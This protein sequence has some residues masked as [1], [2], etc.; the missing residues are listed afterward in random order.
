MSRHLSRIIWPEPT[1]HAELLDVFCTLI[2]VHLSWREPSIGKT[3]KG[4]QVN[5]WRPSEPTA[6]ECRI[7]RARRAS[8]QGPR[9]GRRSRTPSLGVHPQIPW[10][11]PTETG[12]WC[13]QARLSPQPCWTVL[14]MLAL[15]GTTP[16]RQSQPSECVYRTRRVSCRFGLGL[17]GGERPK[18]QRRCLQ[19][20]TTNRRLL[21]PA[22]GES[23][24]LRRN[25]L[26]SRDRSW[27]APLA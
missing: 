20:R 3:R 15:L 5:E 2:A 13:E 9:V 24:A 21:A 27:L 22:L 17:R 14:A 8:R 12:V 4:R 23:P 11:V 7:P 10:S 25:S 18:R 1:S 6:G 19:R 16:R 26:R